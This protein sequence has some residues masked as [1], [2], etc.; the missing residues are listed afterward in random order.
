M[1]GGVSAN[2]A[3]A[4]FSAFWTSWPA[5]R[6]RVSALIAWR[7]IRPNAALLAVIIAALERQKAS[8]EWLREG[9][10]FIPHAAT[11]LNGRRWEDEVRTSYAADEAD[12][13]VA[14][15]RALGDRGWP[16]AADAPFSEDRAAAIRA[17]LGFGSRDGWV[18]AYFSWLAEKLSPLEGFGFDWAIQRS[19][20]LR[21]KEGNFSALREAA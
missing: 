4:S 13:M 15:N 8:D 17:F 21:A 5:K 16:R 14:Y 11:W 10:R 9:G 6:A 7:R 3:E 12:V 20:Y 1:R 19:T 2:D 18:D